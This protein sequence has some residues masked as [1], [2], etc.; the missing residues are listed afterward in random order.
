MIKP[1]LAWPNPKLKVVSKDVEAADFG[2]DALRSVV[3]DLTDTME[4]ACGLGL[5]AI[6]IGIPYR[7]FV[8]RETAG[9]KAYIN[10]VIMKFDGDKRKVSEGCLSIPGVYEDVERYEEI[11]LSAF[12]VDGVE[13]CFQFEG[14]EAQC[15]QHEAEHLDGKMSIVDGLGPVK[16]DLIKRKVAKLV[17]HYSRR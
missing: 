5:A 12:D 17:R 13:S 15:V 2:T 8:A 3:Q 4:A 9:A 10:P 7:I 14:I 6:Q 1:I 11:I 16:R